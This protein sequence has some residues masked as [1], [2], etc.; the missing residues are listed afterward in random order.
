M[1]SA[2]YSDVT[3]LPRRFRPARPSR[4]S[5]GGIAGATAIGAALWWITPFSPVQA[6]AMA[7]LIALLGFLGGLLLSAIKRDR[8]IK[9]WGQLVKGHGGILDRLD[10]LCLSAPVFF[11][12]TRCFFAK[13]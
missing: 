13:S 11:H 1:R 7:L 6:A 4:D 10:S 8:G 2:N 12:L 3:R 5:P 9:D